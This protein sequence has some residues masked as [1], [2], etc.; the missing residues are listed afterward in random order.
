MSNDKMTQ[1]LRRGI[2]EQE[3]RKA[4]IE[5]T[6]VESVTN[7]IVELIRPFVRGVVKGVLSWLQKFFG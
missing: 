6:A 3:Q 7:F 2:E 4:A 1:R 5:K